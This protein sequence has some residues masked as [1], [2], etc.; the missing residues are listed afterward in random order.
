MIKSLLKSESHINC[1]KIHK[2]NLIDSNFDRELILVLSKGLMRQ[3]DKRKALFFFTVPPFINTPI[4]FSVTYDYLAMG[5]F[6]GA[7]V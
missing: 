7:T 3:E 5:M 2:S 6:P 4:N 1:K